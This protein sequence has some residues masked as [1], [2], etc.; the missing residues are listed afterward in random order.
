MKR[1]LAILIA[2]MTC[3]MVVYAAA[4]ADAV[5]EKDSNVVYEDENMRYWTEQN[6]RIHA[7]W[8]ENQRLGSDKLLIAEEVDIL[9]VVGDTLL[10][11][12]P[13]KIEVFH[14]VV[15]RTDGEKVYAE[16]PTLYGHLESYSFVA[17]GEYNEKGDRF[18]AE[19]WD[20]DMYFYLISH[21]EDWS[22]PMREFFFSSLEPDHSYSMQNLGRYQSVS[23][24]FGK[25]FYF[26]NQKGNIA[27]FNAEGKSISLKI[28]GEM[29]KKT[30]PV[31]GGNY[32]GWLPAAG[33]LSYTV[34]GIT[35]ET[36][37]DATA[38]ATFEFH[39]NFMIAKHGDEQYE[40]IVPGEKTVK[41][42]AEEYEKLLKTSVPI[43]AASEK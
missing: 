7:L 31:N 18:L 9:R 13:G 30:R 29:K 21:G 6:G 15:W 41:L 23:Q 24:L 34:D 26:T 4:E 2:L 20:N 40:K 8:G 22:V 19:I 38:K 37:V 12:E 14:M 43:S 11:S 33:G 28:I 25:F 42:S 10:F 1:V 5:P 36:P 39:E 3:L 16:T 35:V 32:V 27:T 17:S